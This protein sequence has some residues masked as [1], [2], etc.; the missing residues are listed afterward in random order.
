[1]KK[2][3]V[4]MFLIYFL[5]LFIYSFYLFSTNGEGGIPF[6]ILMVSSA[7]FFGSL[8]MVEFKIKYN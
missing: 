7:V 5:S 2:L 4:T 6:I 3:C 1:M 8:R